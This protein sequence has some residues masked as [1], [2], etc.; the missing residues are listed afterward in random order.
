LFTPR[1]FRRQ[2][3]PPT[4]RRLSSARQTKTKKAF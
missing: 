4:W 2:N 3:L 1:P